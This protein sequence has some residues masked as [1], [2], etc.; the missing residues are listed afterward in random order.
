MCDCREEQLKQ[1]FIKACL[2]N[3]GY[4]M[5]IMVEKGVDPNLTYTPKEELDT[6]CVFPILTTLCLSCG[7]GRKGKRYKKSIKNLIDLGAD[8]NIT[9]IN[10]LTPLLCLAQTN[11][12]V[13]IARLLISKGADVNLNIKNGPT[14]LIRSC[15]CLYVDMAE[16]LL[17][18]GADLN[19]ICDVNSRYGNDVHVDLP[20]FAVIY[21]THILND[22]GRGFSM[23]KLLL[24]H[25][26]DINCR[27]KKGETPLLFVLKYMR[28]E[29]KYFL[30][31]FLLER[32]ADVNACDKANV[33]VEDI[34]CDEECV[35]YLLREKLGRIEDEDE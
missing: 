12:T 9:S 24:E 28:K 17:E 1:T 19:K 11:N 20:M 26:A 4:I 29:F 18:R 22:S 3:H 8:P 33:G 21:A 7:E 34:R 23:I 6:E 25:K 30:V 32:G 13:D 35:R 10:G 5:K 15:E 31:Q 27:N 2:K 14:P 16:L